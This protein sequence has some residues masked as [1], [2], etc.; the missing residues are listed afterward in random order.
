MLVRP[1]NP[2]FL[3]LPWRE[4][5]AEWRSARIVEVTR[6]IHRHVVRFVGYGDAIYALKALPPRIA[7]HEYRLL[8]ALDDAEVP[9]VG[10][11]GVVTRSSGPDGLE[12]EATLI[13][14]HLDFSLPYR[15]LF[16]RPVV[17]D[18]RNSLLDALAELLVRIHLSGFFWGDC[19]LSNTLFRRDAGKLSAYLVDAETGDLHPSLSDGQRVHDLQ[20]AEE[21]VA[22]E[23]LDLEAAR[24]GLPSQ[25]DPIETA[26]EV[27]R[28]YETLWSELTREDVF[29][30][31]ETYRI[32]ER[33]RRLNGLGFDVEEVR[34]VGEAGGRSLRLNPQ[35]V[36][37]GHHRRRL[38]T[39]TGLDVQ[40]NQ[41][42]RLLNDLATYRATDGRAAAPESVVAYRWLSEVFQPA[43]D[44][45]PAGLRGK[46]EAA[47]LFHELLEHRWFL[48]EAAQRDVG[49]P[50]AVASYVDTVLRHRPDE[51]AVLEIEQDEADLL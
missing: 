33:L 51:K 17:P 16:S 2:D 21:N 24:D 14:R 10:A 1:G 32:D 44:A 41:A 12:P 13:T 20:I 45:I 46:R 6:G 7:H 11:V 27:L 29:G 5:L 34:L 43:I 15:T 4:P 19:S 23:L 18:L 35:V 28:R 22:G 42:R 31:G 37:P 48:S 26:E 25:L 38:H 39:L 49:L 50:A 30:P 3:D 9:V 40:E 36:E 8:R 47:E